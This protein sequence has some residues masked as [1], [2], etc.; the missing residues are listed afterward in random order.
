[1]KEDK[2]KNFLKFVTVPVCVCSSAEIIYGI[3]C[4][5]FLKTELYGA[6]AVMSNISVVFSILTLY[7]A[8]PATVIVGLSVTAVYCSLKNKSIKPLLNIRLWVIIVLVVLG[9]ASR[10]E[11]VSQGF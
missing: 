5:V 9:T 4:F 8:L 11:V 10:L 7:F 1:M 2:Y 6:V 3:L